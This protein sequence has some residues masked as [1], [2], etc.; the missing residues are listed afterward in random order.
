MNY[1]FGKNPKSPRF[2]ES[3]TL[4]MSKAWPGPQKYDFEKAAKVI[5]LGAR[6]G[7]K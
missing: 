7:Y 3:G 5:T 6:R 2:V 1:S 4:R